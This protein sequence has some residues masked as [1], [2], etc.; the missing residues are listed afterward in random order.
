MEQLGFLLLGLVIAG[1][2]A[3]IIREITIGRESRRRMV[4]SD[5]PLRL[6]KPQVPRCDPKAVIAYF[7]SRLTWPNTGSAHPI[8]LDELI[9]MLG[10]ARDDNSRPVVWFDSEGGFRPK[11]A[12]RK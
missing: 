9:S 5:L 11:T 4:A 2:A 8:S 6:R 12:Q 1:P 10:G 3:L 7:S